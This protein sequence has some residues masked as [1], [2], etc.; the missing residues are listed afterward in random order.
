M[1]GVYKLHDK[2]AFEVFV[3][4]QVAQMEVQFVTRRGRRTLC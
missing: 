2:A 1:R 4:Q 3:T